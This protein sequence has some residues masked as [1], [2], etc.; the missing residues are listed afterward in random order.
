MGITDMYSAGSSKTG[1]GAE[2]EDPAGPAK[3]MS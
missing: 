1:A 3:A 2:A